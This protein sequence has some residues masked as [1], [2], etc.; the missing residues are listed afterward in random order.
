VNGYADDL[1]PSASPLICSPAASTA[2]LFSLPDGMT[3]NQCLDIYFELFRPWC[4]VLNRQWL[5]DTL[6]QVLQA[7]NPSATDLAQSIAVLI[8]TRPPTNNA[9]PALP[10][11]GSRL[12]TLLERASKPIRAEDVTIVKV[13]TSLHIFLTWEVLGEHLSAWLQ[14]HQVVTQQLTPS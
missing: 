11:I 1:G 5:K 12:T 6:I 8:E 10:N 14:F 4:P 3:V 7:S 2:S 13:M 9:T